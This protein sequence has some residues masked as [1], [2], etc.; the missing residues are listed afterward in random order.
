M[1]I[2]CKLLGQLPFMGR[3]YHLETSPSILPCT[4]S[5]PHGESRARLLLLQFREIRWCIHQLGGPALQEAGHHELPVSC[6]P[7]ASG[8]LYKRNGLANNP[9][10]K[11]EQNRSG[12]AR[13]HAELTYEQTASG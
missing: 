6:G 9:S 10:T 3:T 13:G 2:V 5:T 1:A 8:V 4:N 12:I 7:I 11:T